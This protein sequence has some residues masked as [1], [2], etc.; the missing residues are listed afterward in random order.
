MSE[1]GHWWQRS[2]GGRII[3]LFLGLLLA[4][5]LASFVALR[6]SLSEHAHR[7]LP[8][9]LQAGERLL[10]NLL[11]RRAQTLI[12]GARLLAADYGFR[13]AVS[14]NDGETIVSVLANHG[15]RIGATEVA[16]LAT[17][18]KL[19]A[20]TASEARDLLPLA[21]RLS[22]QSAASG[23]ASVI[24]LRAGRPY[25]AVLVPIRAPLVVG[26]VLMDFPIDGHLASD[27]Q[28]L[29]ALDLTL[30]A[31]ASASEP[32]SV[33]LTTLD[34]ARA[35]GL[36]RQPWPDGSEDA[37]MSSVTTQGDELGVRVKTLSLGR[38]ADTGA[39]VRA[40]L[41]LSVDDAVRLPRDLQLALIGITL[42]G[43]AV[44]A[45]GS[46]FT[47]RRV[48]TPLRGLADAAERL[49]RGDYATPMR[50][51][52]RHDEIGELSQS[53]ERM[54]INIAEN[55]AQVLKLAYWDS[56]TGLPNRARFREAVNEAIAQAPQNSSVA[57]LML[58]LNRFKHVNDVLGYRIG[59]LLLVQVAERLSRQL[60][61]D[62]DLVARLSGDEF[63]VLLR[64]GDAELALS[65]AR[66]I[67][68]S[69]QAPLM[70]EEHQVDMGAGI[71]IACWPEHA[72]DGDA[73][74]NRAEVAMY[75]AKSRG[76][77]TLMY[78]PSVDVAS[79][80][81]LTLI[82]ELRQAVE[83][84]ELCLYLQPKLALESGQVVG[85]EAL[86]R[87]LHPRR[88]LVPPAEFIPFAE[89]TGFIRALT[90]WVFDAA[91]CHSRTL[92]EEGIELVLSVNLS[93][94]DLLD[95]E[96]PQK[97]EAVLAR[98]RVPARALCLEIT[99]SAMMDDPQRALVTLDR[100]SAMGFKLSIDDFG[101]GYSSLAYL[102]RL[103]V[104]EL[105]IDQSFVRHMQ[106]DADDAMIVRSTIDLAH[107]LGIVVVA[108]GV[109]N[110]QV[111]NMLRELHCDQAQGFHMGRPMP[112]AEFL[113][114][115]ATWSAGRRP[116]GSDVAVL[117]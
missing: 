30:I 37:A 10:Q 1:R 42:M 86:V 7:V 110:L 18:F 45:L 79:A 81:T 26:W 15:A 43:I 44:F 35:A 107:N 112:V 17:D 9:K 65:V 59:D 109:E 100:L 105:K 74:L 69:F 11:D 31:R 73:L 75:A 61:R 25:Q 116:H 108:E 91:A 95:P 28:R 49:G 62:G 40:L 56:L 51:M 111:W 77:G 55:Q 32:W 33:N 99:E 70:L 50:G 41:T 93:T 16:L 23:Q 85:A 104:D 80:Q 92:A 66:R 36:A 24:T 54:R 21:E 72:E 101:I 47:A 102:K 106:S 117:H 58:D 27:M 19:R 34:G 57:I 38:E 63:G 53:F 82:S 114:W 3:L 83:R 52:Q 64:A 60:V 71:G 29:S 103:P 6:A 78:D 8:A 90:M 113:Q 89:Q 14:S 46:V 67:E 39:G 48:T 20:S 98:R 96:L 97:F 87:W 22:A 4:V 88:G 5:Q 2:I 84:D 13:E 68:Q 76:N 115:S 12:N 94:R